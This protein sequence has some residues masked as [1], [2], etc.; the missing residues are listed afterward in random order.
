MNHGGGGHSVAC[1][2]FVVEIAT[3]IETNGFLVAGRLASPADYPHAGDAVEIRRLDGTRWKTTG[4][5]HLYDPRYAEVMLRRVE[6]TAD[7]AAGD[8][9]WAQDAE[10]DIVPDGGVPES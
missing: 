1:R 3:R 2:L 7:I 10:P 4:T 8:E 6:S 9:V 5:N